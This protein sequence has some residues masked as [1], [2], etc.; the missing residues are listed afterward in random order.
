M[1]ATPTDDSTS[2]GAIMN[3]FTE[4][5]LQKSQQKMNIKNSSDASLFVCLEFPQRMQNVK[6]EHSGVIWML[7]RPTVVISGGETFPLTVQFEHNRLLQ[8]SNACS[9]LISKTFDLHRFLDN[10][11]VS[12]PSIL[13]SF[14]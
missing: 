6:F 10:I 8:Q 13:L 2:R 14:H 11:S 1:E 5:D 4:T 7:A 3:D 12:T 9:K